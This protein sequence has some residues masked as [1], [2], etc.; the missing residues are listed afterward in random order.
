MLWINRAANR[1][2]ANS[3]VTLYTF[4]VWRCYTAA[5][6][7]SVYP[8]LGVLEQRRS[9]DMQQYLILSR[10]RADYRQGLDRW[11]DLFTTLT[12]DSWLHFIFHCYTHTSVLSLLLC[13][14]VV[15]W[16]RTSLSFAV[17]LQ[18]MLED[19]SELFTK[20]LYRFPVRK[21]FSKN[22]CGPYFHSVLQS[23]WWRYR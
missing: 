23:L 17:M 12:H 4:V 11:L 8:V 13:S 14:S 3:T 2:S 10:F 18:H 22:T 6:R 16:R 1:T 7:A 19:N 15:G 21:I 9:P 5:Q 20:T